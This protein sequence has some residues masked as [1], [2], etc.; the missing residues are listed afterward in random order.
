MAV[1]MSQ[2]MFDGDWTAELFTALRMRHRRP[3]PARDARAPPGSGRELH[4]EAAGIPAASRLCL[5]R[6]PW[7][8]R[9]HANAA[10]LLRQPGGRLWASSCVM[11]ASTVAVRINR[12][13]VAAAPRVSCQLP[14]VHLAHP[15]IRNSA[16]SVNSETFGTVSR[17]GSN[18]S[19]WSQRFSHVHMKCVCV[20]VCLAA[21]SILTLATPWIVARQASLSMGF[22]RQEYWSGLP[23]PSPGDLPH[24]G[25]QPLSPALTDGFFNIET[26]G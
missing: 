12:S 2:P 18:T 24:R 17:M 4:P 15:G 3:R 23:F 20:S 6:H 8:E 26:L 5:P 13:L 14:S 9:I 11:S 19:Y 25:I 16:D 22:S 10:R 7:E 21:K 1:R